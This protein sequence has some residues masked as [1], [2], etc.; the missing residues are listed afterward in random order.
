[1]SS[2]IIFN[3]IVTND[4]VKIRF[5]ENNKLIETNGV[6]KKIDKENKKIYILNYEISFNDII[7]IYKICF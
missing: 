2:K 7:N 6:I 3:D 5:K 1:M 4:F